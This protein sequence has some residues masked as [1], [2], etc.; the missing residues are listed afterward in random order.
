[1]VDSSL[2]Q[3]CADPGHMTQRP[4]PKN[5]LPRRLGNWKLE[6]GSYEK[7]SRGRICKRGCPIRWRTRSRDHRG[8]T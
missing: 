8:M 6:V 4:T 1:V 5:Q 3:A 2:E 7:F